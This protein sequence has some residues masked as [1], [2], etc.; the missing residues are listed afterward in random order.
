MVTAR[1]TSTALD[2]LTSDGLCDV[3]QA[4]TPPFG[5]ASEQQTAAAASAAGPFSFG[6]SSSGATNF[7][8]TH[9]GASGSGST[10]AGAFT[11]GATNSS[12]TGNGGFRF[13]TVHFGAETTGAG[14]TG[15]PAGSV[16]PKGRTHRG[17]AA[18][19]GPSVANVIPS[20]F[21]QE[22]AP[23]PTQ[24][25]QGKHSLPPLGNVL[26]STRELCSPC[27]NTS[28]CTRTGVGSQYNCC[29]GS[30]WFMCPCRVASMCSFLWAACLHQYT[31]SLPALM[32][33]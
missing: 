18:A 19:P 2:Q 10:G 15:Q 17:R 6:A 8:D 32:S 1:V 24:T 9:F 31:A 7:G 11:F 13:G 16:K 12:T 30:V 29:F 5:T 26:C 25:R 22:A 33:I 3:G 23:F 21:L 14:G 20:L 27:G 4:P 28:S